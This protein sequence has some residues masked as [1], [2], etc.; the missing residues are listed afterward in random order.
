[1]AEKRIKTKDSI[2]YRQKI[3]SEC[4]QRKERWYKPH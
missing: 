1:M 2:K 3:K 4:L